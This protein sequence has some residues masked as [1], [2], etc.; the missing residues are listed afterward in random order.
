M[1]DT[2][3]AYSSEGFNRQKQ[4]SG[5]DARKP[6]NL[7]IY[8]DTNDYYTDPQYV[9]ILR[10]FVDTVG[11]N[12]PKE[13]SVVFPAPE[14]AEGLRASG[15][16]VFQ[17][18][19][20]SISIDNAGSSYEIYD[21][22]NI[23][24]D[25]QEIGYVV[26]SETGVG[27]SISGVGASS[28]PVYAS[29]LNNLSIVS[30]TDNQS[31]QLSVN[32]NFSITAITMTSPGLGYQTVSSTTATPIS[33]NVVLYPF[34][35][36]EHTSQNTTDFLDYFDNLLD[37][38]IDHTA[39]VIR[40]SKDPFIQYTEIDLSDSIRECVLNDINKVNHLGLHDYTIVQNFSLG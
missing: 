39:A 32:N 10:T 1:A 12:Y 26:V 38:N 35:A 13:S 21:S 29:S 24:S 31:A 22:F 20:N 34:A 36:T 33:H 28:S 14:H 8:Y 16:P 3:N 5:L 15:V 19:D 4:F 25:N 40:E 30:N 27:G 2:S 9:S 23:L 37:N 17:I 6:E 11:F 7:E 18:Y